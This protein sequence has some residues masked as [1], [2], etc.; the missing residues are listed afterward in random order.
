MDD[1][2]IL[3]LFRDGDPAAH[4]ILY[5]KYSALLYAVCLR[6]V[7]EEMAAEDVLQE[8]FIAI[9][10]RI[11]SF[12]ERGKGS[13]KAWMVRI[14]V[15]LCLKHLRNTSRFRFEELETAEVP[16]EPETESLGPDLLMGFIR[17]LPDGYRAVFNMFVIEGMS[18]KE[19]AGILGI[20]ESTSASQL[21]RAKARLARII[22]NYRE[23]NK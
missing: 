9:F 15:N 12:E 3:R 7:S 4:R 20:T 16:N 19:I 5:D 6:Y 11:G 14:A 22:N 17:S 13:L 10:D 21:H 1:G 23:E 2:G 8:S 18:H